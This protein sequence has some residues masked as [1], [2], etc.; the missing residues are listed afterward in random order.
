[1]AMQAKNMASSPSSTSLWHA[2]EPDGGTN[3]ASI[4]SIAK[5]ARSPKPPSFPPLRLLEVAVVCLPSSFFAAVEAPL[6]LGGDRGSVPALM[7][8]ELRVIRSRAHGS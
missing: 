6:E 7:A 8:W 1:M 3:P 5:D 4:G 2:D